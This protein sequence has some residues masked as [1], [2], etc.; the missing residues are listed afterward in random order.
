MP[1]TENK[2]KTR[3]IQ[4]E[5]PNGDIVGG[6]PEEKLNYKLYTLDEEGKLKNKSFKLNER[7]ALQT[8]L[9]NSGF[10]VP[11]SIGYYTNAWEGYPTLFFPL[12]FSFLTLIV[13]F[14]LILV[15]LPIRKVKK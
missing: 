12:L 9:L 4:K 15:F 3:E 1:T 5:M 2:K 14:I 8:E 11:Y 10:V 13:V 6:V 7:D